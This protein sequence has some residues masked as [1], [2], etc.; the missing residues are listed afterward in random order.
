MK[1]VLL[2]KQKQKQTSKIQQKIKNKSMQLNWS[3]C[4]LT[5][6]ETNQGK[7]GTL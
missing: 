7:T 1:Y 5:F 3:R 6:K 2:Q 4:H